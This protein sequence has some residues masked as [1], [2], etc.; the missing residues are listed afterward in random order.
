MSRQINKDGPIYNNYF[1]PRI[2]EKGKKQEK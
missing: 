1:E 2:K